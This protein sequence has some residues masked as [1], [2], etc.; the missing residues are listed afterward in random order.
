MGIVKTTAFKESRKFHFPG[1]LSLKNSLKKR[2]MPDKLYREENSEYLKKNPSWHTEDSPWKARQILK[3]IERNNHIYGRS[4]YGHLHHFSKD[5]ALPTLQYCGHEIV[6]YFYT[7]VYEAPSNKLTFK[8]SILRI[9]G[10][11]LN[12]INKDFSVRLSGGASLM[13]LTK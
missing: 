6:D 1:L 12:T 7:P 10:S 11:I 2:T 9:T 3:I 13:V 4:H 5:S 8:S